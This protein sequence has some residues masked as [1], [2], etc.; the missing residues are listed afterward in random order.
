MVQI[1]L[2]LIDK[3][4]KLAYNDFVHCLLGNVEILV[5]KTVLKNIKHFKTICP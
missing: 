1:G 2:F 4:W 3:S 5:T